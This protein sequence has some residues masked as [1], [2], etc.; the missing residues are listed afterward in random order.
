MPVAKAIFTVSRMWP[1]PSLV[2]SIEAVFTPR[3]DRW[4]ALLCNWV[5]TTLSGKG[6]VVRDSGWPHQGKQRTHLP[7]RSKTFHGCAPLSSDAALPAVIPPSDGPKDEARV[8][9]AE[10]ER[11]RDGHADS[12]RP[13][14]VGDQTQIDVG[15]VEIDRRGNRMVP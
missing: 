13:G 4:P 9:A 10:T 8:A 3:T 15:I 6:L 11:I 14:F 1:S 5:P 2:H 7:A 12:M